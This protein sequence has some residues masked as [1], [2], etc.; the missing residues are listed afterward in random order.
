MFERCLEATTSGANGEA[1]RMEIILQM[2]KTKK[3]HAKVLQNQRRTEEASLE[4]DKA[5]LVSESGATSIHKRD[6]WEEI[7]FF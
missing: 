3:T 6:V 7:L 5:L 2:V 4:V 1:R